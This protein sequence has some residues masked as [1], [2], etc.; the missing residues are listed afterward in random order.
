[1]PLEVNDLRDQGISQF[2]THFKKKS[3]LCIQQCLV[4]KRKIAAA[5]AF[6]AEKS[7]PHQLQQEKQRCLV[8]VLFPRLQKY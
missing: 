5:R 7:E 4:K 3:M 1:M 6:S 2:E 8:A